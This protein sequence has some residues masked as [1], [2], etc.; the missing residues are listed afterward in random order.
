MNL[1]HFVERENLLNRD[2]KLKESNPDKEDK[3]S[4]VEPRPDR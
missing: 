4:D 3:T 1:H 2:E